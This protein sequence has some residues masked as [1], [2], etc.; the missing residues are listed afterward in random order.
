MP[1]PRDRV[2]DTPELLASIFIHVDP[3]DLLV[4]VQRVS[5]TWNSII[6]TSLHLQRIIF[7]AP[8]PAYPGDLVREVNPFL[9]KWFKPWFQVLGRKITDASQYSDDYSFCF[10]GRYGEQQIADM[11]AVASWRKMVP[12]QPPPTTLEVVKMHPSGVLRKPG[13]PIGEVATMECKDGVRMGTLYDL[14]WETAHK[15]YA[16]FACLWKMF[17]LDKETTAKD[18]ILERQQILQAQQRLLTENRK[19]GAT[20]SEMEDKVTVLMDLSMPRVGMANAMKPEHKSEGYEAVEDKLEFRAAEIPE[21]AH[22]AMMCGRGC[23][24]H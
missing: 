5:K 19:G 23:Q 15:P 7:M 13:Q 18:S 4:N 1:S 3:I 17:P 11:R 21:L 12:V 20:G 16:K 9:Q 24:R 6:E 2:L 22:L 14:G 8:R 10:R